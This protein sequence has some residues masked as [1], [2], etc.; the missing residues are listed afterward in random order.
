MM[1]STC[2]ENATKGTPGK[3]NHIRLVMRSHLH[4][5]FII[6]VCLHWYPEKWK[7][8]ELLLRG[9]KKGP[10]RQRGKQV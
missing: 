9:T 7:I 6:P 1:H 2:S 8:L 5:A 3:K 4:L 10:V